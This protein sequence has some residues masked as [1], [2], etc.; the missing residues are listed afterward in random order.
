MAKLYEELDDRLSAFIAAQHMF[1]VATAPQDG[2]HVNLS[3]KA[4]D[5]FRILGSKRV[6]YVDYIGSGIETVAHIRQNGRLTVMFCAFDGSPKILRLYGE[7]RA[8]EPGDAEFQ[9]LIGQFEPIMPV[10]S[11]VVLAVTRI[12]DACGYGVPLYDYRGQ[13][14]QLEKWAASKDE[15]ALAD[16]KEKKN[17]FSID[18]LP[19]LAA[20]RVRSLATR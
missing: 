4:L 11:I 8:V 6:A 10:R 17:S 20:P 1:F 9:E 16:Y 5:G 18:G 7:G 14:A 15:E 13:R 2:G 3:P 19:G 12:A